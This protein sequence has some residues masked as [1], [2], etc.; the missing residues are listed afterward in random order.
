VL[1]L[2]DGE[3]LRVS[4]GLQYD[5]TGQ[6]SQVSAIREDARDFGL[7]WFGTDLGPTETP[8]LTK[9]T[10]TQEKQS[11]LDDFWF[12]G[13]GDYEAYKTAHVSVPGL[14]LSTTGSSL[15]VGN[16]M[17]LDL[18]TLLPWDDITVFEILADG[19]MIVCPNQL[20]TTDEDWFEVAVAWKKA[21]GTLAVTL[22][23]VYEDSKMSQVEY[24]SMLP[25]GKKPTKKTKKSKKTKG[26]KG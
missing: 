8:E 24:N 26:K 2:S 12:S 7:F 14:E 11:A 17:P 25:S 5:I 15:W 3:F 6:L 4:I 1:F 10:T 18:D 20:P 21:D 22:E 19:I 23:A 13:V 16:G 9:Y